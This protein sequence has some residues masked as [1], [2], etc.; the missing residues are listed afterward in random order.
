MARNPHAPS[1]VPLGDGKA[2]GR[3]GCHLNPDPRACGEPGGS[4]RGDLAVPSGATGLHYGLSTGRLN[5][6]TGTVDVARR[7][8]AHAYA[9]WPPM[10]RRPQTLA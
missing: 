8:S 6:R 2:R 4:N 7:L 3:A 9:E 5:R 1:R 10:R